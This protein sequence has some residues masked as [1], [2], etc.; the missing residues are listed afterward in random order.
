MSSTHVFSE[1]GKVEDLK[2]EKVNGN[3]ILTGSFGKFADIPNYNE[4]VATLKENIVQNSAVIGELE[5]PNRSTIELGEVSH[6]ITCLDVNYCGEVTGTIEVL[7]TP[8]GKIVDAIIESGLPLFVSPRSIGTRDELGNV[9]VDK[10][11]TFDLIG[12]PNKY[13]NIF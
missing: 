4:L 6:K 12:S 10:I 2:R 11:I 7:S 9:I 1:L 3:Y 13:N 5:H 8:K